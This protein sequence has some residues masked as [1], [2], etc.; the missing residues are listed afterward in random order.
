MGF[1]EIVRWILAAPLLF[2]SVWAIIGNYVIIAIGLLRER[3]PSMIPIIGGVC[4]TLGLILLPIPEVH[5]YFWIPFLIDPWSVF[6]L[7][8]V[9][10]Y[11][12]L[13]KKGK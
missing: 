4:G 6:M 9:L 13:P 1:W 2:L 12:L 7:R 11:W 3:G 5:R 8:V 10:A